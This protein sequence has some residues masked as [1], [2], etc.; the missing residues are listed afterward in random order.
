MKNRLLTGW[1]FRRIIYLTIGIFMIVQSIWIEQWGGIAIGA[2]F[3]AM[4]LFAFGCA[5]NSCGVGYVRPPRRH[6]AS[7]PQE[8]EYEEVKTD[9]IRNRRA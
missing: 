5:G 6:A 2:Y 4:G 8:V 1:N 9:Q 3:A 7:A